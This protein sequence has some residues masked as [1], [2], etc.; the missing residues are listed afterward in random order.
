MPAEAVRGSDS[1]LMVEMPRFFS[2]RPT[3][4][5]GSVQRW[6]FAREKLV[7]RPTSVIRPRMDWSAEMSVGTCR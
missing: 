6:S 2:T 1:S 3:E 4:T 5:F 7:W